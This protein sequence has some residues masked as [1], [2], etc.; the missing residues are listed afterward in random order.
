MKQLF[1]SPI[2]L[3]L[4]FEPINLCN[5]K[6][7]CCPYTEFSEEKTFITQKMSK[8][9]ITQLI[10]NWAQLLKK[11]VFHSI[12][13]AGHFPRQCASSHYNCRP[14]RTTRTPTTQAVWGQIETPKTSKRGVPL[15][16]IFHPWARWDWSLVAG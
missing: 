15:N 13:G 7:F 12:N 2:P 8:E 11:H 6:C 16:G 3:C 9:Q 10:E 1:Y 5:A 4:A 14:F